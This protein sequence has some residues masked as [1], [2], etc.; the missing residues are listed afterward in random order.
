MRTGPLWCW[1]EPDWREAFEILQAHLAR[2]CQNRRAQDWRRQ[3]WAG[4]PRH[5]RI[6][7]GQVESE[8]EIVDVVRRVTRGQWREVPAP[9]DELQDRCVVEHTRDDARIGGIPA[10]ER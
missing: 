9:L 4:E 1:S 10:R 5:G 8:G 2:R 3:G 7:L 6:R